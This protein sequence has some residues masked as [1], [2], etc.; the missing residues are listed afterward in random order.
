MPRCRVTNRNQTGH[1][2][3]QPR[4]TLIASFFS[5]SFFDPKYLLACALA[6]CEV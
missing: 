4:S 2:Y 5:R 6:T 1:R 3:N